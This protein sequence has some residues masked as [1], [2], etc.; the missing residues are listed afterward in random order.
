MKVSSIFFIIIQSIALFWNL[1]ILNNDKIHL[2]FITK[3]LKEK[4]AKEIKYRNSI[5]ITTY[6][7]F[8]LF[9]FVTIISLIIK[10]Q[11]KNIETIIF[12][13]ILSIFYIVCLLK[14]TRDI[15]NNITSFLLEKQLKEE[16]SKIEKELIKYT[17]EITNDYEIIKTGFAEF[18]YTNLCAYLR[19]NLKD[20]ELEKEKKKAI[21]LIVL[22][23]NIFKD[24]SI[25]KEE[26]ISKINREIKNLLSVQLAKELKDIQSLSLIE[27]LFFEEDSKKTNDYFVKEILYIYDESNHSLSNL[28]YLNKKNNERNQLIKILKGNKKE[29][30]QEILDIIINY[31][32][33]NSEL[34]ISDINE[35]I[36]IYI[37]DET[38]K[39]DFYNLLTS[40]SSP[41]IQKPLENYKITK[42]S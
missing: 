27:D 9:L 34:D 30:V 37:Q 13:I 15:N 8:S 20:E 24:N 38:T 12:S 22:I 31:L 11:T 25:D 10:F 29:K 40:T 19:Y 21:G 3:L 18:Y 28:T 26:N 41:Y 39:K 14:S 6:I 23:P 35:I 33:N 17:K 36:D 42:E 7:V 4:R 32:E 1:Y 16:F 5:K 2:A